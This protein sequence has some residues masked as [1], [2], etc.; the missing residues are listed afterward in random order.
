MKPE[1]CMELAI[2]IAM[3]G[4]G[5]GNSPFGSAI[6][7][8]GKIIAV[9]H[10]TVLTKNDSTNHA[11]MNAIVQ[12]AKKG[13]VVDG[14]TAYVT[15]MPCT[16]CAKAL[17]AAGVKRVVVFSDYHSTLATD[18]FA[19]AKVQIDKI[20]MPSKEIAYDLEKYTSARKTA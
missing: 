19:K 6:V 5:N 1:K 10:N 13:H 11:E 12:A 7:K 4:I 3:K 17:I 8:N 20:A 15:N 14:G 16:T 2:E 18:F 9:A